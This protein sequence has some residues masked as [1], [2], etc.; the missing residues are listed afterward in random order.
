M[1]ISIKFIIINFG[2]LR[3]CFTTTYGN[4]FPALKHLRKVHCSSLNKAEHTSS[5]YITIFCKRDDH[6]DVNVIAVKFWLMQ[7]RSS[8]HRNIE[9][10][11]YNLEKGSLN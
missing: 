10:I 8:I 4:F 5:N 11:E 3:M 1:E 6:D 2:N 7:T 9:V